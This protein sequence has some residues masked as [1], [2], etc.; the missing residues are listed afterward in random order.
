[1][2]N[3]DRLYYEFVDT[4]RRQWPSR[5][6]DKFTVLEL[7]D[8][9]IPYRRV[10]N[11]VG[12]RSND[13]YEAVLS[14]FLAGER[15]YL[16]GDGA[17]QEEVRAGLEEALPDIRRYRAFPNVY[18]WLDPEE[19]PPP[20]DIRYAPPELREQEWT[21]P[22]VEPGSEAASVTAEVVEAELSPVIEANAEVPDSEAEAA[23]VSEFASSPSDEMAESELAAE[24]ERRPE[25]GEVATGEPTSP[26][27]GFTAALELC[28]QCGSD[29]PDGA[30]FCPFCGIRISPER[31]E[32]CGA[33]IEPAWRFCA[34]CGVP[35]AGDHH[36]SA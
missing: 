16:L 12:F 6:T 34:A 9:I 35:R 2:D 1:M 14:R 17:M 20:G 8:E 13:D 32:N 22:R 29:L 21:P 19:I 26:T 4:L 10:R 7:H 5:L 11:P 23:G 33:V 3:L 25:R 30:E 31:C 15:G 18:V 24:S 27:P 28:P 36:E